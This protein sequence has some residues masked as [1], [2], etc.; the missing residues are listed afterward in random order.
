M[1][2]SQPHSSIKL[3]LLGLM[4]VLHFQAGAEE[5]NHLNL[6]DAME[7]EVLRDNSDL[8]GESDLYRQINQ[9]L[10]E[11]R[12][13]I[14]ERYLSNLRNPSIWGG[15]NHIGLRFSKG[16]GDFSIE[17]KRDV[18]PDLFSDDKWL[19]TDT[20]EVVVDAT[21]LLSRLK[22]EEAIEISEQNLALFA[23]VSFRRKY[24][25]MHFSD[26]YE[27]ALGFNLD[28]LFSGHN[29]FKKGAYLDLGPDEFIKREDSFSLQAG[30]LG[31]IPLTSGIGAHF[32]A[33]IK[34]QNLATATV[35]G[36]TLEDESYDGEKLRISAEK[37]KEFSV[38]A[39]TGVVADFFNILRLS[40]LKF[41]IN[42]SL[43]ES[44]K[45][46][47]SLSQQAIDEYKGN[48]HFHSNIQSL[49]SHKSYDKDLLK[50]FLV[51]EEER[52]T[53]NLKTKYSLLL[54][55]GHKQAETEQIDL[56]SQNQSKRFFRHNFSK[57][58]YRDNIFSHLFSGVFKALLNLPMVVNQDE[59]RD[60]FLRVEYESEKDLVKS[61]EDLRVT[62]GE[63][64]LSM[65]FK[66]SYFS[67]RLK[68]KPK[69]K[70]IKLLDHFSGVDPE[71]VARIERGELSHSVNFESIFSIG[72]DGLEH[73]HN[74]SYQ[75]VYAIID[76]SCDAQRKKG[77]FDFLK[78]LLKICERKLMRSYDRYNLER[79]TKD[80]TNEAYELCS[81]D[82]QTYRK[83]KF[84]VSPRRKRLFFQSCMQQRLRKS[85][86]EVQGEL[87]IWRLATLMKDF[88]DQVP[89]KLHYYELFG[90]ANMHVH[91]ELSGENEHGQSFFHNFR[92]GMFKGLG[93]VSNEKSRLGLRSPASANQ[94]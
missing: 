59:Y 75:D 49:L 48:D 69:E 6:T 80:Y 14:E 30:G 38:G 25:Y 2:R 68:K 81:G 82:Y 86:K 57:S 8:E 36:V 35:Q 33:L 21:K 39:V 40:L 47:Y 23:G 73:M 56:T 94:L 34:Y 85:E 92:E 67:Y 54:Y 62:E 71:I 61:K 77:L 76:K 44:H 91:G 46:Y 87:P 27:M 4:A 13:K 45:G 42:Y 63:E 22:N 28:K 55:G 32:G 17:L 83:S 16:F 37:T 7:S 90:Y 19:V 58:I 15:M 52:K 5:F 84:W 41:E 64:K 53:E 26:S 66:T 50:E 89:S 93:V 11:N 43:S 79:I 3:F 60:D 1:N 9:Y 88:Q 20:F 65:N 18:A 70:L 78:G 24:T 74:L 31:T 72:K 29:S 10:I 51:T 12:L